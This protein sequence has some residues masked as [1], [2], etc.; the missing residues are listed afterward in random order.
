M[1]EANSSNLAKIRIAFAA[2]Q[3]KQQHLETKVFTDVFG[4]DAENVADACR[5]AAVIRAEAIEKA[6]G[7]SLALVKASQV[8]NGTLGH[9]QILPGIEMKVGA[10]L[11]PL[12]IAGPVRIKG[13]YADGEYYIPLATN[14]AALVAGAKIDFF[15][16]DHK[17]LMDL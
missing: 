1:T 13:R 17:E 7:A 16:H 6:T 12:G 4:G 14:E 9:G 8:D 3:I 5:E 11:V 2:G 15:D 10:A